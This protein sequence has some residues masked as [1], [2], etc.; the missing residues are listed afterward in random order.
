MKT[1][2]ETFTVPTSVGLV[3]LTFAILSSLLSTVG[4]IGEE[5]R[6]VAILGA[7]PDNYGQWIMIV[8]EFGIVPICAGLSLYCV[9]LKF[10]K[11]SFTRNGSLLLGIFGGLFAVFGIWYSLA[12]FNSYIDAIS[13]ANQT[14]VNGIDGPLQIIYIAY[15][16][17]GI[18]WI[19]SGTLISATGYLRRVDRKTRKENEDLK[20]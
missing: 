13:F 16:C 2:S 9:G 12:A 19:A 17:V 11:T 7:N 10:Q 4:T 1:E 5:Y 18:L 15:G 3:I 20:P 6:T 14:N 8:L